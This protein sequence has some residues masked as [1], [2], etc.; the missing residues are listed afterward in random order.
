MADFKMPSLGAD[1]QA[2]TL[3]EWK[4]APGDRVSRG[5]IIAEIE[6]EKGDIDVEVFENGRIEELVAEPGDRLPVGAVMARIRS[7]PEEAGAA[8]SP[9]ADGGSPGPERTGRAQAEDLKGNGEKQSDGTSPAGWGESRDERAP[10]DRPRPE[11]PHREHARRRVRA[12][13]LARRVA[14]DLGVDLR[15]VTGSGPEGAI[16]RADVEAAARAV[17]AAPATH[18]PAD[19]DVDDASRAE[20]GFDPGTAR[21]AIARA[22]SRSNR[23]IPHYYLET[24]I[25]MQ[26]ALNWLQAQNEKRSVEERLLP[27]VPLLMAV[28]RALD[29][30]P[31][32][33]GY[34]RNDRHEPQEPIHLGVAISLR[35]GGLVT[36][37]I[38]DADRK[39]PDE[40]MAALNDLISRARRGK[41]RSSELTDP[42][43]TVTSLGDLG[44]GTV[45]G[46]IYPPQVALVGFGSVR[47]RPWAENGLLGVRPVLTATLAA[48]HR[49]TDGRDGARFLAA[50][51]AALQE[52]D[53]FESRP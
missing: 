29:E 49:A 3:V 34:W 36:P 46:V 44:V 12:S 35:Q 18:R 15:R 26:A 39:S 8:A 37:A 52:P 45:H 33:N 51:D 16:Q 47:E 43:I 50:I 14:E 41:L 32:L 19:R 42:T 22:M 2:A 9:E 6:T 48:D 21:Q 17:G 4:V 53:P 13:P 10:R 23:E 11:E 27:L 31:A 24:Q 1:M 20:R 30:V 38:H 25:D 28:A 40:L 5:D 7:V